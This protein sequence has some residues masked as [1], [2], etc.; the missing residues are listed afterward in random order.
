MS[1]TALAIRVRV[2]RL[3]GAALERAR[4][5]VV[6]KRRRRRTSPVPFL[7]VVSMLTVGG[8]VGL[9]LFNTSMQQA[10]FAATGLQRQADALQAR[11][12]TL[13]MELDQLRD[14]QTIALKAQRMGMVLPSSPAVLDLKT[15][16]V[17]GDPAPATGLD[18]LRLLA[19]PPRKPAVLDP[20]AQV[21]VVHPPATATHAG[22]DSSHNTAHD[23][24][25]GS[26]DN[27]GPAGRND[28]T[29]NTDHKSHTNN[30]SHG[31]NH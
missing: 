8:I 31:T 25:R 13:Q 23:G 22:V 3:A 15:G 19:P 24:G 6:P 4:L 14:P 16:K 26:H 18:R 28:H 30:T 11:Q 2:P 12:Q 7:L 29:G 9:L 27:G 17:L 21:T 10:S 1:S 20:P 5:T